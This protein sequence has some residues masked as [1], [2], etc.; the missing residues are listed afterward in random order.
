MHVGVPTEVK[1]REYRVAIT[2]AGVQELTRQGHEV[3]VQRGAGL[4]S[5]ISDAD[6]EAAGAGLGGVDD[7]WSAELVLKVKEPV[8]E[9]YGRLGRGQVLFTYLHLAADEPL[10]EELI[11]SG[12]TAIA[13]ETVQADD[14][15]LPLLIPMSEVAGRLS[16]LVGAY[17]LMKS[18]GGRGVLLP[19][20]PG[21][22]P[23]NV[24]VIGAGVVG[25]NAVA[26]AVAMGADVT[27]LNPSIPRLR[28]VD[29]LYGGRVRT[30]TSS[31]YEIERTVLAA[32][33]VIGAVLLPGRRTPK[34]VSRELVDNLAPGTVLVDVAIDQGGCFEGSRPTTHD[35]PTFRLGNAVF[36]CVANMPGA[37]P[38]TSTPALT[39]ATLPYVLRI[40][41]SGWRRATQDDPALARGVNVSDGLIVHAGTA[42]AFPHL[43]AR[44][45]DAAADGTRDGSSKP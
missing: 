23:A 27:V 45:L 22:R 14:G 38:A 33:L 18:Q 5:M 37:V 10:T 32:D 6:Y 41:N 13:Y 11:R 4:G 7:A 44:A 17:N 16:T 2:P 15:S 3:I 8:A 40:A 26:Q 12:A 43:R 20:V 25:M 39:N 35:E 30:V 1:N 28:H 24:T 42:E 34:L 31:A 21:V 19:G 29:E 36:Y 9:E